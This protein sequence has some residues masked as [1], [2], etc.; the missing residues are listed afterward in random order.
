ME[1]KSNI[2][3]QRNNICQNLCA[4]NVEVKL[5]RRGMHNC[6]EEE[7]KGHSKE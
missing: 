4:V 3:M 2:L 5:S 1:I 7:N 6:R